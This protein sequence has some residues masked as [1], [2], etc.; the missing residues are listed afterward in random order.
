MMHKAFIKMS[1]S[2]NSSTSKVS[3]LFQNM[4]YLNLFRKRMSNQGEGPAIGINLGTT[5][6]CAAVWQNESESLNGVENTMNV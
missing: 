1:H 4:K 5:Y 2:T 3:D 6:S